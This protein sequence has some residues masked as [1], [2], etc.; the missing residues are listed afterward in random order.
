[1]QFEVNLSITEPSRLSFNELFQVS[2]PTM[3]YFVHIIVWI[4][5]VFKHPNSLFFSRASTNLLL[6]EHESDIKE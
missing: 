3:P 1:M 5:A 2:R 4:S 6:T